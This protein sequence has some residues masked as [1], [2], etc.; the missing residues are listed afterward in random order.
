MIKSIYTITFE[1]E[2]RYYLFNSQTLLFCEISEQTYEALENRSYSALSPSTLEFLRK[3]KV[4]VSKEEKDLFYLD[5]MSR[6]NADS[7]N[8]EVM[9]LV[10]APTTHCNFDCPYCFE[11]KSN[12]KFMSSDVEAELINFIKRHNN[13]KS[14][15]LTWYGGEPL[16]AFSNI[17]S[18]WDKIKTEFPQLKIV[19]HSIVTNGWLVNDEFIAFCKYSNLNSI[20]IT[21]DGT[22]ENHNKTRCLKNGAPTFE[23]I[24]NNIVKLAKSL[25]EAKISVRV[26]INRDNFKDYAVVS[27]QLNKENLKNISTYPG[28][29][30][31]ETQDNK[32]FVYN[33]F[34]GASCH[35]FYKMTSTQG[36]DFNFFPKLSNS[37]GCMIDTAQAYLIGP[38]GEIY[39]CWNDLGHTDRIVG[40]IFK[41]TYPNRLRL[42]RYLNETS[43]FSDAKCKDCS[44]FP[45]CDGG[46]GHYRYRNKFEGGEYNIC[47]RF[48]N[49]NVL[50]ESLLMSVKRGL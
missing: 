47:T 45:I 30:R 11:Q 5:R 16:L 25:P 19:G 27:N 43:P 42:H 38:E 34:C 10:I 17:K 15:D 49:R 21:L 8:Q 39:K 6:H 23:Q 26:N 31:E 35:N 18:I 3:H 41:E 29:I 48:K 40:S 33:S 32:T 2:S 14:M 20:Q 22:S 36:V 9:G 7:Y 13:L 44:V 12:T 46:C 37:K 1:R 50:E 28:F 4:L 24:Y